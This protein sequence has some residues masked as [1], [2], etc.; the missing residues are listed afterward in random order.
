MIISDFTIYQLV[1]SRTQGGIETHILNLSK[2]LLDNGFDNQVIFLK[3]HGSSSFKDALTASKIKWRCL[4]NLKQLGSELKSS[5]H[6]LCTH[7]YK[8]GIIG[9]LLGW[10]ANIPTVSTYHSGDLGQGKMRLYSALDVITSGLAN[11]VISV[12]S[13]INQ[14]LPVASDQIDNFIAKR[15]ILA[16]RGKAIAFVGRA[17]AEKG[18]FNFAR[19]VKDLDHPCHV[20]G[21]GPLLA[22]LQAQFPQIKYFGHVDMDQHWQNIGLLCIT[23]THEGLPLVALE[24]MIRGI[25]VLSYA[26]GGLPELISN[27]S[28]GWLIPLGDET[29]FRRTIEIW[30]MKNSMA[31]AQMAITAHNHIS[32]YYCD[33]VICPKLLDVYKAA[34]S[35]QGKFD[36]LGAEHEN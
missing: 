18:P 29:T 11:K 12:S 15:P 6:I 32:K 10:W 4:S 21:D 3:D 19:I 27:D 2:W 31:K 33:E 5:P 9:R 16:E 22:D 14:R 1:D 34:V 28:N 17:S 20:Y 25:P 35:E 30:C 24:A 36:L 13:E 26:I 23:S 8:A 7:G